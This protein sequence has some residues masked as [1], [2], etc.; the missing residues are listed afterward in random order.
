MTFVSNTNGNLLCSV[1]IDTTGR[2][3]EDHDITEICIVPLNRMFERDKR[4]SIFY[5]MIKPDNDFPKK[6]HYR[7][8]EAYIRPHQAR[9]KV[10]VYRHASTYGAKSFEVADGLEFWFKKLGLKPTKR[11]MPLTYDWAF[12]GSH[13]RKLLGD[14]SYDDIFDYRVRDILPLALAEND[15]AEFNL[16]PVPF[17]KVDFSFIAARSGFRV[18]GLQL[19]VTER[20]LLLAQIYYQWHL[21]RN[22]FRA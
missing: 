15:N 8:K 20:C 16:A 5:A 18:G 1:C 7:A 17:P 2:T 3:P 6:K 13:I 19:P 14:A 11:I 10:T 9:S 21:K 22:T 4:Y 12:T